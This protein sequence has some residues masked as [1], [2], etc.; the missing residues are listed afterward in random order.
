MAISRAT[1]FGS[2]LRIRLSP[3]LCID[4]S[5][6]QSIKKSVKKN[7]KYAINQFEKY[8]VTNGMYGSVTSSTFD[9][10]V[11]LIGACDQSH[12]L[13]FDV[14]IKSQSGD[15]ESYVTVDG[16]TDYRLIPCIQTCFAYTSVVKNK[17]QWVTV[18]RLR[19][20]T[21]ELQLTDNTESLTSTLDP[22][23]LVVVSFHCISG[24]RSQ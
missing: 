21:L 24:R 2:I 14:K 4:T 13:S 15:V 20:S 22:E 9:D 3:S 5:I 16:T 11:F 19:V 18:R 10:E 8:A 17:D 1:A 6:D 23:A 12:S 7:K